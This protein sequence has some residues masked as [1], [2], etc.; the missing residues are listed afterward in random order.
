MDGDDSHGLSFSIPLWTFIYRDMMVK[1]SMFI[2]VIPIRGYRYMQVVES[3]WKGGV[4]RHRVLVG[5]GRCN[6]RVREQKARDLI[7]DYRPLKRAHVVIAELEEVAGP[8]QGKGYFKRLRGW[9]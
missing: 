6:D 3:Y 5:L 7:R 1:K 2:R 8:L 4:S 9:R